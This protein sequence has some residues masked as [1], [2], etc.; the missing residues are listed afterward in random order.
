MAGL[1]L[2]A[3]LGAKLTNFEQ[4]MD[5]AVSLAESAINNI[6]SRFE[7]LNP[8]LGAG[9]LAAGI[10]GAVGGMSALLG[11]AGKVNAELADMDRTARQVGLTV[12]KFQAF[13][14]AANVGGVSNEGFAEGLQRATGLLADAERNTNSLGQLFTANGLKIKDG[15]DKLIST[16][17]L[18]SDAATLISRAASE[19]DKIK[20][21]QMLGFTR[22]WVPVLEKGAGALQ[23]TASEAEHLGLIIQQSTI[24]KAKKFDEEWTKASTALSTQLRAATAD[25]AVWLSELIDQA[26][27]YVS[28]L[29]AA[30]GSAPGAGQTQFNAIADAI[31]I[32]RKDVQ[33]LAQ[34]YDQV[35]RAL[36]RLKA[37]ADPDLALIAGLEDVQKKA[38][39]AA[40]ELGRAAANRA[41]LLG[42]ASA[43]IFPGGVPLPPSRPKSPAG[44]ATV[45]PAKPVGSESDSFDNTEEQ[46]TRRTAALNADSI[47]VSRNHAVQAQLRAEFQLLNAIRKDEGEVTQAQVDQYT[48]LRASMSAEQALI[49]AKIKLTPEHKASFI[50]ASE[51]AAVATAGYDRAREAVNRLNSASSQIGSALSSAFGDAVVDGKKLDD[52]VNSLLKSFAKMAIN[53][54]F[55]S[56]FN[57]GAGG[58]LSPAS[59]FLSGLIPGFAD[60]TN[61]APGGAAWV[62]ENGKELVNLPRGS[63]VIPNAVA[64][65][66]GSGGVVVNLIED[67]SRAGQ[68]QKRDNGSGGFDLTVF[69]DSITAKNAANPGS[70]TS[71]AL[72]Q[73][74]R[75]ARR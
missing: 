75:I 67:A 63:Q 52:V 4:G 18:L 62:G 21:A 10:V 74:G 15:N 6:E 57:P 71:A 22:E 39:E 31:D 44:P 24:D 9:F 5:K 13:R 34:D 16:N 55:M 50:A 23:E 46:I 26:S 20:I 47:A 17:K 66:R 45:I 61:F 8:N 65:G 37:K 35:T 48:L 1:N 53:S 12:E 64:T 29:A 73:R 11:F 70:A 72:N 68:T 38:R 27:R 25:A 56:I 42:G 3:Q 7:S 28:A 33:G 30:N 40:D 59:S 51:G 41:A 32:V 36:D 19:Q 69:V 60:G 58:G 49:E 43:S 2:E 54:A 14:F